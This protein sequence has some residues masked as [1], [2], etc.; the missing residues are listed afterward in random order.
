MTWTDSHQDTQDHVLSSYPDLRLQLDSMNTDKEASW[1]WSYEFD[2]SRSGNVLTY[3]LSQRS[4]LARRA[5]RNVRSCNSSVRFYQPLDGFRNTSLSSDSTE[6]VIIDLTHY[7]S[8]RD[9]NSHPYE[10]VNVAQGKK[11]KPAALEVE[12]ERQEEESLTQAQPL[13]KMRKR[14]G[15]LVQSQVLA[16]ALTPASCSASA[17][18]LRPALNFAPAPAFV[19]AAPSLASV[20]ASSPQST[21]EEKVR[22][23]SKHAARL[24]KVP[25][26]AG[27]NHGARG[28]TRVNANGDLEWRRNMN[29][30]WGRSIDTLTLS[31]SRVTNKRTV[32]AGH[33][34]DYRRAFIAMDAMQAGTYSKS[35]SP[36][37]MIE[38]DE[39]S[40]YTPSRKGL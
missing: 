29:A 8:P 17:P 24:A 20:P 38:I 5:S 33:H 32:R 11:R 10:H 30:P 25:G 16:P 6:K 4:R 19:T 39:F 31:V 14:S 22:K 15:S 3:D 21:A 36:I 28:M 18:F 34:R 12:V 26:G 1:G 40:T 37:L 35:L 23:F 2:W 7:G 27:A 9:T 13:K